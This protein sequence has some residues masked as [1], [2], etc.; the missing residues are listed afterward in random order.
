MTREELKEH[1]KK[2]VEQCEMWAIYRSEEPSGKVYEE[3]K[4]ILDILEQEPCDD[5]IS[6]VLERMW[7]CRGKNATSIDKVKM[8]QIIREELSVTPSR[9]WIPVS[10]S[11]PE[12]GKE[13]LVSG[14]DTYNKRVI[15]SKYQG[16][17][18][19]F[20][21]GLVSAWMPLPKPY[22]AEMEMKNEIHI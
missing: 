21:C 5:A 14:Y 12:E 9:Q 8:E 6:R 11:L 22:G 1:C 16:E 17:K 15:I 13:V 18:Y 7:N 2:T 3:H 20:T 10:E 4:A 19:G